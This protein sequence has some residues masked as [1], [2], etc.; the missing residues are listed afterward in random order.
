M[1]TVTH[2]NVKKFASDERGTVAMIFGLTSMALLFAGGMAI[3]YARAMNVRSRVADAADAAALAAGKA[4]LEGKLSA[5]Q[6]KKLA[7]K[8]FDQN[9]EG[10]GK[11]AQIDK[12][13]ID[14]DPNTGAVK[15]DVATHVNMTLSRIA[16]YKTLDIPVATEAVFKQRDLE[17]GMAL[18]ITGSMNDRISGG[19][20]L[21]GLKKA[22][23]TFADRLMPD[24]RTS[25][26]N[27][28]IAV[29][30]YSQSVNLGTY[31]SGVG[32]YA[33]GNRWVT[34]RKDGAATDAGGNY[35]FGVSGDRDVDPTQNRYDFSNSDR[36]KSSVIPL[37]DDK[38][39]LIKEVNKFEARGGTAGHL[40]IQWAWNL[41][42]DQW[43]STFGSSPASYDLVKDG[44]LLKA[45][46]VMTDG[47]FNTA[48]HGKKSSEQALA[49]CSAM[50]A[51]GLVV[52]TVGFG[53]DSEPDKALRDM[54]KTTL[55]NC[56]TS[57]DGYFADASNS[58]ELEH[59]FTN[60]A[61]KLSD[62]RIAK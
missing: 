1:Q 9:I 25:L 3:D 59:A 20:K 2:L 58:E 32:G 47:V 4:L 16:G 18:D 51:K 54:A 55:K 31:A 44:K 29:A 5:D 12:P 30:P 61:G 45:V 37:S 6:I 11:S 13:L 19:S 33:N 53:L 23:A 41:V 42:S 14:V 24:A 39:T 34:E 27:V 57:G 36:P 15:V 38:D 7:A 40:G 21:D 56:A 52:F 60:F 28:H 50:K 22:F 43:G 10:L 8:Y 35:N 26:Q 49:L 62:L 46:V 48:Y 17:I